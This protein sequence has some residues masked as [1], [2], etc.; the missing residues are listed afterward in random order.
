MSKAV[1]Y[2]ITKTSIVSSA[3]ATLLR[4]ILS[5]TRRPQPLGEAQLS[6]RPRALPPH[7]CKVRVLHLLQLAEDAHVRVQMLVA[8]SLLE[9]REEPGPT[10][11]WQCG[12]NGRG[13]GCGD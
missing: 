3:Y 9:L 5:G 12:I 8:T 7:R 10:A 1:Q 2:E 13:D 4:L 11:Q 6:D